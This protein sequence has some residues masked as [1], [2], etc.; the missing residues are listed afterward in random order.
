MQESFQNVKMQWTD[1]GFDTSY[2][3]CDADSSWYAHATSV[4]Q[5]G[6]TVRAKLNYL[7]ANQQT[8]HV[9][10]TNTQTVGGGG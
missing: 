3:S 9:F 10:S 7:D 6:L 4:S 5:Q 2:G 8:Q 1:V